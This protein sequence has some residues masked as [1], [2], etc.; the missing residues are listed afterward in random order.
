MNV[1][2]APNVRRYGF[3]LVEMLVALGIGSVVLLAI[4]ALSIYSARCF[5]ALGNYSDLDAQ[6]RN[7]VDVIGRDIRQATALLDFK[8]NSSTR[9]LTF[10]NSELGTFM[11]LTWH[12]DNKTLSY[13]ATDSPAQV[14]LTGCDRWSFSLFN[15]SPIVSS[16]NILFNPATNSSGKL[17]V[18]LC[19]LVNMS[20]KC[21]RTI[22]GEKM[23]T[24]KVQTA[25]IVLRNKVR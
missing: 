2:F 22:L 19:K 20:W 1:R 10:T 3:T 23:N 5:L 24:E 4:C 6:S 14:L 9:Y 7:T 17:D 12:I 15:G 8:A 18:T 13:Q 21:S 16:T 11:K 25:Q